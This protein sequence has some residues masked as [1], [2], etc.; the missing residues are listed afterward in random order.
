MQMRATG[1]TMMTMS[2]QKK[3]TGGKH[4]PRRMV[5]LPARIAAL[6]NELAEENAMKLTE[7]VKSVCVEHLKAK[8]RWATPPK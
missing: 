1:A 4:K 8:G 5:G 3:P 7:Y 6:M 2:K